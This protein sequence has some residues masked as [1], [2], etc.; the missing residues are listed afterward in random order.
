MVSAAKAKEGSIDAGLPFFIDSIEPIDIE[1]GAP[2]AAIEAG[3]STLDGGVGQDT[4]E[5][6]LVESE[7]D[8]VGGDETGD[9]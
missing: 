2:V 6:G 3:S 9:G 5:A 1:V 4:E 7:C 8:G